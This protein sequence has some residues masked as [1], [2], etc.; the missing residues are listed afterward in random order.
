[1]EGNTAWHWCWSGGRWMGIGS[2]GGGGESGQ[3]NVLLLWMLSWQLTCRPVRVA[4]WQIPTTHHSEPVFHVANVQ[5]IPF[6]R[7]Q[8]MRGSW[9]RW[10]LGCRSTRSRD[11]KYSWAPNRNVMM[12]APWWQKLHRSVPKWRSVVNW[13]WQSINKWHSNLPYLVLFVP[14][15][16]SIHVECQLINCASV[17]RLEAAL[18][19]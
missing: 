5:C 10:V 17:H 4:L 13:Q 15:V 16:G 9:S 18:L 11:D 19:A 6:G 12:C 3:L 2:T 1:M 7:I 8:R 14:Y